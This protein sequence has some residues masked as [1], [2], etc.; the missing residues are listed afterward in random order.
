ML[1]MLHRV[2]G[3]R[4]K[5]SK[6]CGNA[7][8]IRAVKQTDVMAAARIWAENTSPRGLLRGHAF[9]LKKL[10]PELTSVITVSSVV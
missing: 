2:V 7:P 8:S 3:Q 5:G 4:I 6:S 10:S 9:A 1:L